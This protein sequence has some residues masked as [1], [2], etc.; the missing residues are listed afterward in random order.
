MWWIGLSPGDSR[1]YA[2]SFRVQK[3][4]DKLLEGLAYAW[5]SFGFTRHP[6]AV[7][8]DGELRA[9]TRADNWRGPLDLYM[10]YEGD[11]EKGESYLMVGWYAN[12]SREARRLAEHA[13]T[14][15]ALQLPGVREPELADLEWYVREMPL[16]DLESQEPEEQWR[17]VVHFVKETVGAMEASGIL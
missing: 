4:L 5:E 15:D 11:G 14:V 2:D 9:A 3:K 12:G 7:Y 6:E 10:W 1:A 17:Q 13:R 8:K 16:S